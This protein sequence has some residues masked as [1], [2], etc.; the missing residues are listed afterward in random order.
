MIQRLSGGSA[1]VK[2]LAEPFDMALPSFM[3]H[4][5]VL[6]RSG[7]V[8]SVKIGRIRTYN[9]KPKRLAIA[10]NW[11]AEQQTLWETRLEQ[12]DNYAKELQEKHNDTTS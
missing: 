6:E 7:L 9:I 3:Q 10:K 2:V 4:L 12:F 11:L 5:R 8:E 1:G